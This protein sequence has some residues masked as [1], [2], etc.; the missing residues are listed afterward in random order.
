ML[1]YYIKKEQENRAQE[2]R[3]AIEESV[4]QPKSPTD[5]YSGGWFD[6]YT[7]EQPRYPELW[8]YWS[9]YSQGNRE[10]WCQQKGITLPE[11]F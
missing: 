10:Y 6:G 2:A 8:D 5:Q 4:N 9:G 3:N 7:G 11:E 1:N